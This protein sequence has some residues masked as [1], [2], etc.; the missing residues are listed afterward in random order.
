M[1][2]FK[3]SAC[4]PS[5]CSVFAIF[6]FGLVSHSASQVEPSTTEPK[7]ASRHELSAPQAVPTF[8]CI[9]LYWLQKSEDGQTVC[10]IE[11]RA[12]GEQAWQEAL[13]LWFDLSN[14]EYRGSITNLRDGTEYEIKLTLGSKKTATLRARTWDNEFPIARTIS[15]PAGVRKAPLVITEGGTADGYICYE[16]SPEGTTIDLLGSW[17][18]GVVAETDYAFDGSPIDRRPG[19]ADAAVVIEADYVIVKGVRTLNSRRW[20]VHIGAGQHHVVI[21]DC[22][23]SAFGRPRGGGYGARDQGIASADGAHH[24]LVQRC[25][26]HDPNFG[27]DTW[28]VDSGHGHGSGYHTLGPNAVSFAP[29]PGGNVIRWNAIYSTTGKYLEDGLG[30][31]FTNEHQVGFPGPD[32]DIYQ[33]SI[34]HCWD[35]GIEADGSGRNVRIWGNYIYDTQKAVSMAPVREGPLYIFRN[36]YGLC[37]KDIGLDGQGFSGNGSWFSPQGRVYVLHNTMLTPPL[38]SERA[39]LGLWGGYDTGSRNVVSRN[40]IWSVILQPYGTTLPPSDETNSFDYD[41]S[42]LPHDILLKA[43]SAHSDYHKNYKPGT[44]QF[45]PGS[46]ENGLVGTAEYREG[47]GWDGGDGSGRYQLA[48]DSLGIDAGERLPGFNDGFSGKGP[49]IGAHEVG[50]PPM[51]FGPGAAPN[52]TS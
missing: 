18:P 46:Q 24:I 36:V 38:G 26:I 12:L 49:D 32:S 15:L 34:R 44:Q 4:I 29:G 27:S 3:I 35:E 16:A 8:E 43:V 48:N 7:T 19:S 30:N 25:R 17:D 13:P 6:S 14:E 47:H 9:G 37:R 2:K 50:S 21:D 45:P 1:K 33:N 39:N 52:P 22:D 10:L 41:L 28:A 42:S 5:L 11:Y 40:N 31:P 23:I 20:G 51:K